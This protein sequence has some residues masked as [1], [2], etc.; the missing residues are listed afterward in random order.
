[1][2]RIGA[3]SALLLVLVACG[4][5]D[6][7]AG[8]EGPSTAELALSA[9]ADVGAVPSDAAREASGLASRVLRP[10]TGARSPAASDSVRIHYVGWQ[11]NGER[12]DSSIERGRP[13]EF[14]V[15][16]VVPGFSEG[17]QLMVEGEQRRLWIPEE[18]AYRGEDPTGMLV[19]DVEL[20]A[21]L[22]P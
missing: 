20:I 8:A 11:T 17:L 5:E 16:R 21:I 1:M 4:V 14:E 2:L 6:T 13:A 3:C 10:G 19:F 18:L 9:P 22:T 7:G 12:F 15:D